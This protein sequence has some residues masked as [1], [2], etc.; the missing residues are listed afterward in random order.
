MRQTHLLVSVA[1]AALAVA[2][3]LAHDVKDPVCRMIVDSDTAKFKH[4]LGNK[5]FYFCSKQC[6]TSFSRTPEK[7]EKL[8]AQL[9]GQE[10]RAYAASV[11]TDRPAMAGKPVT[12]TFALRYADTGEPVREFERVHERLLHLVM[13]SDDL[14][15]FE[16]QHPTRVGDGSFKLTWSFPKPG[17]YFLYVDFTPSDGDNQLKILPLAV[18]GG[19]ER[20][21]PLRADSQRVKQA[22]EYRIE[23]AVQPEPLRME[24]ATLLTYTIRDRQGRP[25]R[26][27]Q[28]FI[29]AMGHLFAVSAD[30]REVVHTHALQGTSEAGGPLPGAMGG[31]HLHVTPRM[32][33]ERGPSFTFKFTPPT[34]GLY[35]LWAQFMR[36]N[37]VVTVPFTLPVAD[38]W[39]TAKTDL[40]PAPGQAG[41][42]RATIVIDGEYQPASVTVRA[43]RPV[44]LTFVRKEDAGCGDVV[45]IPS[46]RLKRA[47]EPGRKTVVTFTP[48]KTGAIPFTCGMGMYRG[49]VIVK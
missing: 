9:E 29:G 1:L 4:R 14:A 47:L 21:R 11:T 5:T 28:P 33:T 6:E 2:P 49:Q 46:L 45:Q 22:G 38:L 36:Q 34:G 35:K 17:R 39:E 42:Q 32:V 37:R 25:V 23:L 19:P 44:A 13:V 12:I 18:G 43:G 40:P 15:W 48:R 24:R 8:A 31:D 27:M 20:P 16:H 41:V 7:Y 30:G 3:A 26:D 10:V